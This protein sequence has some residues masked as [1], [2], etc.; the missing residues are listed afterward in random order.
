[1]L[2]EYINI[3]DIQIDGLE[4][5]DVKKLDNI[6][7][8][9]SFQ[10]LAEARVIQA[11]SWTTTDDPEREFIEDCILTGGFRLFSLRDREKAA[12][13]DTSTEDGTAAQAAE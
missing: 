12:P 6:H 2:P 9:N 11:G 13:S 4:F 5:R 7:I 10:S 3:L 1:M 8:A